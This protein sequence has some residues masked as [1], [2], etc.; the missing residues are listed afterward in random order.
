MATLVAEAQHEAAVK[1]AAA[2]A[3]A[4][5]VQAGG[6]P[7][8][9][10]PGACGPGERRVSDT[11]D[12]AGEAA[13]KAGRNS[14][15]GAV[16]VGGGESG[17][18][19]RLFRADDVGLGS[20]QQG[21]AGPGYIDQNLAWIEMPPGGWVDGEFSEPGASAGEHTY[22]IFLKPSRKRRTEV[23]VVSGSV[24]FQPQLGFKT[25]QSGQ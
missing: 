21:A 20:R 18:W 16:R 6:E 23:Q 5:T 17:E 10:E 19:L 9:T 13:V 4:P 25:S 14:A 7:V 12:A 8:L 11:G 15:R 22:A 2:A 24:R 1:A 3:A